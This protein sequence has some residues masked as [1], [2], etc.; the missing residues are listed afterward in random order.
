MLVVL[1]LGCNGAGDVA[2]TQS[3]ARR[4]RRQRRNQHRDHDFDNL[5]LS[6]SWL[7]LKG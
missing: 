1:R 3:Q 4:Q 7:G 6:H 5:F 2:G